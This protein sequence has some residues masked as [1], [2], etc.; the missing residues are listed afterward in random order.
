MR[1]CPYFYPFIQ[2]IF[3]FFFVCCSLPFGTTGN[4]P[5][6]AI[7]GGKHSLPWKVYNYESSIF[8]LH[9]VEPNH[10]LVLTDILIFYGLTKKWEECRKLNFVYKVSLRDVA[11]LVRT[12][13]VRKT[14]SEICITA[15]IL[16]RFLCWIRWLSANRN[17]F[18]SNHQTQSYIHALVGCSVHRL[19]RCAHKVMA[20]RPPINLQL[21]QAIISCIQLQP[22]INSVD[23]TRT[24]FSL[25]LTLSWGMLLFDEKDGKS[26][27]KNY[28]KNKREKERTDAKEWSIQ[29]TSL[30]CL[31]SILFQFNTFI[32]DWIR[33]IMLAFIEVDGGPHALASRF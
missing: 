15:K 23:G 17:V 7:R 20:V 5:N 1:R 13:G 16:V 18:A 33:I 10:W 8:C 29:A 6:K 3:Y 21:T 32:K 25:S 22:S 26:K 2:F 27:M 19:H 4:V 28:T 9:A 24:S 31:Q 11:T 12:C 30:S 14:F